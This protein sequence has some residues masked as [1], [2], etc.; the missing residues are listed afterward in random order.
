MQKSL[1]KEIKVQP[2]AGFEKRTEKKSLKK[3]NGK[4]NHVSN[5]RM[6]VIKENNGCERK[7]VGLNAGKNKKNRA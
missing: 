1:V 2:L 5:E 3:R 7:N 6:N 4:N